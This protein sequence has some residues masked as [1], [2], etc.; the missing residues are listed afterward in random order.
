MCAILVG[1]VCDLLNFESY[2]AKS[3]SRGNLRKISTSKI[4]RYTVWLTC[5]QKRT[6]FGRSEKIISRWKIE[7][8]DE[9]EY[10]CLAANNG[11]VALILY[12]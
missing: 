9:T 4:E 6:N 10:T 3:F 5:F 7:G 8:L 12:I 1:G 11:G 2:S